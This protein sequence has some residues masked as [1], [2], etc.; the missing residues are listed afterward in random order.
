MPY[1]K[2][3]Q[4]YDTKTNTYQSSWKEIGVGCESCHGPGSKHIEWT[5]S[6]DKK[7]DSKKGWDIQLTSGSL[8]LWQ[9]QTETTKAK[10][11][12]PG[13]LVQVERCAQCHSRRS[14]IHTG[15][16][17]QFFMDA[18]LPSLLDESLYYPDGQIQDEVYEYGS[19]L[20]SKMADKGVTCSNCHNPHSGKTKIQ[21]NGLCLQCHN[22]NLD[23]P[24]HTMHQPSTKGSYCVDCHMPTTNYM[25]VDARRDHS[26][27]IPRPDLSERL[28]TPMPAIAAMQTNHRNGLP[29]KSTSKKV[30]T[31]KYHTT[32]RHWQVRD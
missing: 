13:N 18:F 23:S 14:R 19:F 26:M 15:N 27:R 3:R 24:Q 30:L 4:N 1:N 11:T 22:S 20:Q 10:R 29:N 9:H 28:G 8:Q 16:N 17:E 31:G 12:E 21:G 32:A 7:T 25:T 5:Q 2:F 6:P